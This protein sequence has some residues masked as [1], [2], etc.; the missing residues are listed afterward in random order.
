VWHGLS[1]NVTAWARRCLAC[2]WGK[3]HRHTRL[4]PIP[5]WC[6]SHL[7]VDLVG[8]LQHSNNFI[9]IFTIFDHTSKWMEAIP[10]TEM[11]AAA[12]AKA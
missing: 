2:Q 1:S 12:C 4:V 3:I 6:F 5:Q 7:H 11:S 10:L 9:Y 8:P